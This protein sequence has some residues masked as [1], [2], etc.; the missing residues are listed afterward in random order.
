MAK[1]LLRRVMTASFRRAQNAD[2]TNVTRRL[3]LAHEAITPS[4]GS[5]G[6]DDLRPI[7]RQPASP[8]RSIWYATGRVPYPGQG[9]S[10]GRGHLASTGREPG[11]PRGGRP[12]GSAAAEGWA[13]GAP[14]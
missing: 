11:H 6:A 1:N 14:A 8:R 10:S 2:A 4:S 3:I 5:S 12:A 13:H 9:R 7:G